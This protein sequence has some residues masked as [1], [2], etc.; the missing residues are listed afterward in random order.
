M[1]A[2]NEDKSFFNLGAWGVINASANSFVP[3]VTIDN[4]DVQAKATNKF[5]SQRSV[6]AFAFAK[7]I[8]QGITEPCPV[9]DVIHHDS[10]TNYFGLEDLTE[11]EQEDAS[12]IEDVYFSNDYIYVIATEQPLSNVYI[13]FKG[14]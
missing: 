9:W 12:V 1:Y 4:A 11:D 8:C 6:P 14:A 2:I 7:I 5:V 3:G 13:R 10:S